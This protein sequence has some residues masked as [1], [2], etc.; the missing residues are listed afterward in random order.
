MLRWALANRPHVT[1]QHK[2]NKLIISDKLAGVETTLDVP[3]LSPEGWSREAFNATISQKETKMM[4]PL[5]ASPGETVFY[6]NLEKYLLTLDITD[7]IQE[8]F[9]FSFSGDSVSEVKYW[10]V[11][12][13]KYLVTGDRLSFYRTREEAVN[14]LNALGASF[15]AP[16][17]ATMFYDDEHKI[18]WSEQ[19]KNKE[20]Y[21]YYV[22][23]QF[24]INEKHE[25][26]N[27][28]GESILASIES[29]NFEHEKAGKM[30]LHTVYVYEEN[31]S[32]VNNYESYIDVDILGNY[33]CEGS[34]VKKKA[35]S[36][37]IP[38]AC[39]SIET[40]K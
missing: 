3:S 17:T 7:C 11:T 9:L 4:V 30:N 18:E 1:M 27:N 38:W 23:C 33:S 15:E 28:A 34:P 25:L 19:L 16:D 2:G 22:T 24:N 10:A 35:I 6:C 13:A 37:E 32:F 14:F 21:P 39:F 8:V 36:F 5:V 26:C 29:I 20:R 31:D 12:S 40:N